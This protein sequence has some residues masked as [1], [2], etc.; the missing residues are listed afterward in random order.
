[1]II[2][3][4]NFYGKFHLKIIHNNIFIKKF[5]KFNKFI[6]KY[7]LKMNSNI[8][9]LNTDTTF[10]LN[11]LGKDEVSYNPQLKMHAINKYRINKYYLL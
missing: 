6:D 8:Q 11:K 1:M 2:F 9:Y 5:N 7:T 3:L 4:L 10:I